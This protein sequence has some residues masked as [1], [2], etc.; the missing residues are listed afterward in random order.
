M[1]KLLYLFAI[2]GITALSSCEGDPGPQ[3][4]PGTNVEAAVFELNDV[5]F[6]FD[7]GYFISGTYPSNLTVLDSDVLLVYRLNDL[8]NPTTPIWQQIPRTLFVEEGEVDYDFDF[9]RNDYQLYVGGT[10]TLTPEF[11][12]GQTFRLVVIPGYFADRNANS[13]DFSDYNA[14]ARAYNIKESDVR[15]LQ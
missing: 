4:P 6:D 13:I 12:D 7:N 1:K 15:R 2:A 5:D 11:T 10:F 9:S 3:G 14:V 8:I